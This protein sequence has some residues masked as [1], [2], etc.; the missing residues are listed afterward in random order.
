MDTRKP[1]DPF[2]IPYTPTVTYKI[3]RGGFN[4]QLVFS[5]EVKLGPESTVFS[6]TPSR[7]K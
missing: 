1:D 2:F 7:L 4:F 5:I 3:L 6:F